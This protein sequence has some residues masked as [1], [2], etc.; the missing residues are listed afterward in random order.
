[1]PY[2]GS[3]FY[4]TTYYQQVEYTVGQRMR[5]AQQ[6]GES[7]MLSSGEAEL[8]G[9]PVPDEGWWV[10]LS[11]HP[12]PTYRR[13][14]PEE[15]L[16]WTQE[17]VIA[18]RAEGMAEWEALPEEEREYGWG[19]NYVTPGRTQVFRPDEEFVIAG[20]GEEDIYSLADWEAYQAE[21]QE[22]FEA[23][24][25]FITL[26]D[27][28]AV[29]ITPTTQRGR[30]YTFEGVGALMMEEHLGASG[31]WVNTEAWTQQQGLFTL[32]QHQHDVALAQ[33]WSYGPLSDEYLA[34]FEAAWE[35]GIASGEEF[36]LPKPPMAEVWEWAQAAQDYISR[37]PE[38]LQMQPEDLPEW[39]P[40]GI[41]GE[42]YAG[43]SFAGAQAY[44]QWREEY[45]QPIPTIHEMHQTFVDALYPDAGP[46]RDTITGY[47]TQHLLEM[48][49][50]RARDP[51]RWR[52]LRNRIWDLPEDAARY[53]MMYL[54]QYV[55]EAEF[56][57]PGQLTQEIWNQL[58]PPE[59][60]E[61]ISWGY[62][63]REENDAF[64][65]PDGDIYMA[66][67][68]DR[69]A[70]WNPEAGEFDVIHHYQVGSFTIPF[71][72]TQLP[73]PETAAVNVVAG[74][75]GDLM[76]IAGGI[77]NWTDLGG[78]NA[79]DFVTMV[80]Q[81]VSMPATMTDT[82]GEF[83][84]GSL[85]DPRW[86]VTR[87]ARTLP[88]TVE[89][90]IPAAI[91]AA[92]G[93]VAV[94]ALAAA[95][96]VVGVSGG[97]FATFGSTLG[98]AIGGGVMGGVT[99]SAFEA[100]DAYN[101]AIQQGYSPQ[102]A[103]RIA[104]QVFNQN[105]AMLGAT[106]AAEIAMI[107]APVPGLGG[108]TKSLI[109]RG[110]ITA[111]RVGGRVVALSVTEAG[112]EY[113]QHMVQEVGLQP[114]QSLWQALTDWSNFS[115]PEIQELMVIA[116]L[117][118][119]PLG[120]GGDVLSGVLH[121][122]RHSLPD[123]IA[124]EI[125]TR[126]EILMGEGMTDTQA[127]MGALGEA[128]EEHG[129]PVVDAI[130]TAVDNAKLEAVKEQATTPEEVAAI[131][132]AQQQLPQP[133]AAEV[134]PTMEEVGE[135]VG[136]TRRYE[137]P[138]AR[139]EEVV[140][141]P[142]AEEV[143]VRV[144]L[145]EL[146][147]KHKATVRQMEAVLEG[148]ETEE[149]IAVKEEFLAQDPVATYRGKVG[150]KT[151]SLMSFLQ[152]RQWPDSVTVNQAEM[153][154]MGK[155]PSPAVVKKGRVGWEYVMDQLAEHFGMTEQGL[156]DH[157]ENIRAQQEELADMKAWRTEQKQSLASLRKDKKL[158]EQTIKSLE[159]QAKTMP[160]ANRL[161]QMIAGR[162]EMWGLTKKARKELYKKTVGKSSLR[163][164][165]EAELRKVFTAMRTARPKK[166]GNKTVITLK[167]E[168][169]IQTLK[170]SLIR[171][172]KLTEASYARILTELR[173][174]TDKYVNKRNFLTEREGKEL[175]RAMNDEADIVQDQIETEEALRRNPK[176]KDEYELAEEK[177]G[178]EPTID[179]K[180]IK[181]RRGNELRAMRYYMQKLERALGVPIYQIWQRCNLAHLS[182]RY[183]E[184]VLI[185]R[186]VESHADF[187][188][189][190][191]SERAL[192]R[193]ENWIAA[194]HGMEG[195]EV[196]QDI[197]EGELALAKELEKQLLEWQN[198]VRFIRVREA[199]HDHN[200]DHKAIHE[201]IPDGKEG[202]TKALDIYESL[203]EDAMRKFLD[204]QT[205]GV[206][207]SGYTPLS[208]VRPSLAT[209]RRATAFGKTHIKTRESVEFMP[210]DRNILQRYRSYNRQMMGLLEMAPA[211]RVMDRQFRANAHK[212][213]A[214]M[215]VANVVSRGINEL[216]GY[217]ED[218]GL[219]V[220]IMERVYA[221]VAAAT[222]WMPHMAFR[223][224]FQNWAFN[225]D[226][227]RLGRFDPRNWKRL[228]ENR[229]LYF[230]IYV[231]QDK[232]M[233]EDY[234]LRGARA[235]PG[236]GTV[237]NWANRTSL[238]PWSDKSNRAECF[239]TRI[240]RVDRALQGYRKH[241]DVGRL[242]KDSG[243]LS[244]DHVQQ[245]EALGLLAMNEVFIEGIGMVSGQEAFAL[246]NAREHTNNVHFLYDRAQRS[247]A[248][249]GA[250]GKVLGNIMTFQRSWGERILK[251]ANVLRPGS[252]ATFA[253]RRAA[254]YIVLGMMVASFAMG[255]GYSKI[256]GKRNPYNPMNILTYQPGGL[257][258]GAVQEAGDVVYHMFQAAGGNQNSLNQLPGHFS[259]AGDLFIPFY[260]IAS[261]GLEGALG[262]Q[263]VDVAAIR[264][265]RAWIDAEYEHRG[266]DKVDRS[267]LEAIQHGLFGGVRGKPP[268]VTDRLEQAES[269][270]DMPRV[271]DED[272][273][274]ITDAPV[275]DLGWLSGEF[276]GI[277]GYHLTSDE[278]AEVIK[279]G[280][281]SDIV[282]SWAEKEQVELAYNELVD[283]PLYKINT[284]PEQ[285]NTIDQFRLMWQHYLT[286]R[287]DPQAVADWINA[288]SRNSDYNLGNIT[289]R[290]YNL[291][292]EYAE[293]DN[294]EAFLDAHPELKVNP[295][296]VWLKENPR[297]NALLAIWTGEEY[298]TQKAWDI[299]QEIIRELD[300]PDSVLEEW[301]P[302][303]LVPA[304]FEYNGIA[305]MYGASSVQADLFFLQN[306]E[307]RKYKD[308]AEIDKPLWALTDRVKFDEQ[309]DLY[310][311]YADEDS[312]HYIA[313]EELRGEA[314]QKL[315]DDVSGF[316]EAWYEWKAQAKGADEEMAGYF[317]EYSMYDTN[318][319]K[320]LFRLGNEPFDE[321]FMD[322]Y[323]R[324]DVEFSERYYQ[325]Q[326]IWADDFD[327][328]EEA[329]DGSDYLDTHP[330]FHR[331]YRE[332]EAEGMDC[333][334]IQQYIEWYTAD[335]TSQEKNW[336]KIQNHEFV[337]WMLAE[338]VWEAADWQ[339]YP[340]KYYELQVN[341]YEDGISYVD[342]RDAHLDATD[343]AQ[344][345][346]DHPT[347]AAAYREVQGYEADCPYVN[348]WVEYYMLPNS[349]EKDLYLL[350][351][352]DFYN[353]MT[354]ED[355]RG[356]AAIS[357]VDKP[358]Q[359]VQ[360]LAD[361]WDKFEH[362]KEI[363]SEHKQQMLETDTAFANA[364]YTY[365]AL[366]LPLPETG[367]RGGFGYIE[368]YVT[369][370]TQYSTKPE[371]HEGTWYADDRWLMAH[372]EFEA[373]M[374]KYGVWS[375]RRD[376]S[377]VPS[378]QV[379]SLYAQYQ[380]LPT[381]GD[382]RRNFRR[383][384]PALDR[385]LVD[386]HGYSPVAPETGGPPAIYDTYLSLPPG[387]ERLEFRAQHP[388]LDQWLH[389]NLGYTLVT[390][391]GYS[392]I[393]GAPTSITGSL[394][395]A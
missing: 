119:I 78:G 93:W 334:Y 265:I 239:T 139:A 285:G 227:H 79:A 243:L 30:E 160:T 260:R 371:D 284:D 259:R 267:L 106:N 349:A 193:V 293:S 130:Q 176:I 56:V 186:L 28:A 249:M 100:G 235:L 336:W 27:L 47:G 122:T 114:G 266:P 21:L 25:T 124:A 45:E 375:R 71:V 86:W 96:G 162:A 219:L 393:S 120:M 2:I 83:S 59:M 38:M 115:R 10:E 268:S 302:A 299:G 168:N 36:E 306:P 374:I 123:D 137:R 105:V 352:E 108:A 24:H 325:I 136:V 312:P 144:T 383:D 361:N 212:L 39:I 54:A 297:A 77:M 313:D 94:P 8:L 340:D 282:H 290:E 97:A 276:G 364:Y 236:F 73:L 184:Q 42:A 53:L 109:K 262:V 291:L 204:T 206:I 308:H 55:P 207:K 156:I 158:Q 7:V 300:I 362:Y 347:Y 172:G 356:N 233:I 217:H 165:D 394:T 76:Q 341:N 307:F 350:Q 273:F 1:M 270:L 369:W 254:M 278:L 145:E 388:E 140:I 69:V 327:A 354:N 314:R 328:Y 187:Y 188:K 331:A 12:R 177:S 253:E 348:Q 324:D 15:Q 237:V 382:A 319:E 51:R 200:G 75:M 381:T 182:I 81:V 288:D 390:D 104:T 342:H 216:K 18:A 178:P 257:M 17:D 376:Y 154:L 391:Q 355:L 226:F 246:Y 272:S 315:F 142:T 58:A 35:A 153:L 241:G 373:E 275:Y 133:E 232:G 250:S 205:W 14:T 41:T 150:K 37:I 377:N 4:P 263:N 211:V 117:M 16:G 311:A 43:L 34:E 309:W 317:A 245:K 338:E 174:R 175:I 84:W 295:A 121:R 199:Y 363:D 180:P 255:V 343:G 332:W 89:L 337:N 166:I 167:T 107:I 220:H 92:F 46:R 157:I 118:G 353:W 48:I 357:P 304:Y 95:T 60:G 13:P 49:L 271:D 298:H 101:Q 40:E 198:K 269:M 274:S 26:A 256:T 320:Y 380:A 135:E 213:Q 195:V 170:A 196:P 163:R 202:L 323:E 88:L 149:L 252:G 70:M 247:P 392:Y 318:P 85:A 32:M 305:D 143:E 203:G 23:E 128:I 301:V 385:W 234:L 113:Y 264:Q 395:P 215:E 6:L 91:G 258:L 283:I 63:W 67:D 360:I 316:E 111:T 223:N 281:Y 11:P 218:G 103:D 191:R 330:D 231:A 64:I 126:A 125:Q 90:M 365:D 148:W 80:G 189:I 171:N 116:G 72:P 248:E 159:E 146:R 359:A 61:P 329:E 386:A 238:F 181:I 208:V 221:Q 66:D 346:L 183:K 102:E 44:E 222:F 155:K 384:N 50:D 82:V 127:F 209:A 368:E 9:Y 201:D 228:N 310:N 152:G 286:I 289:D 279:N 194:K 99:E 389:D 190:A 251:Q 280:D 225:D 339:T 214:P 20:P 351:N 173:L 372:P 378:E 19:I 74:T 68:H 5:A 112:Q 230:E 242:M 169:K 52:T 132:Y 244:L 192:K 296:A 344:Y 65:A 98:A 335:M 57:G 366:M 224:K 22:E 387:E 147:A 358:L 141:E 370:Y 379:E 240:N 31:F 277:L 29:G 131:D 210:D 197:T 292:M 185:N 261:Q 3:R 294:P 110:L 134:A 287:D 151:T 129:Q 326:H 138:A 164:M 333:P 303:N 229:K 161:K 321:W 87:P 345:L 179:G 62:S 33:A 322:T 367:E